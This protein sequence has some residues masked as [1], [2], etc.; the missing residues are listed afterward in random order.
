[1]FQTFQMFPTPYLCL[2]HFPIL[3]IPLGYD[4]VYNT[5]L[6]VRNTSEESSDKEQTFSKKKKSSKELEGERKMHAKNMPKKKKKS[7]N[8]GKAAL[9]KK[10]ARYSTCSIPKLEN[11]KRERTQPVQQY[12]RF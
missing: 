10:A 1:M 12:S 6:A 5:D 4:N 9:P 8:R 7:S 2:T 3:K 11:E